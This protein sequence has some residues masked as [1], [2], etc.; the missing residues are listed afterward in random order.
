MECS[1]VRWIH[2]FLLRLLYVIDAV[3]QLNPGSIA[4]NIFDDTDQILTKRMMFWWPVLFTVSKKPQKDK[5]DNKLDKLDKDK[6]EK[7]WFKKQLLI[8][9][10]FHRDLSFG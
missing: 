3:L 9:W 2:S 6:L 4:H 7:L 1:F 10:R 5:K 8:K